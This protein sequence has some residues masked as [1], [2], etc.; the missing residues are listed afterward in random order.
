[1]KNKTGSI[2]DFIIGYIM[3]L[4]IFIPFCLF[5]IAIYYMIR[6]KIDKIRANRKKK[7][8]DRQFG[9]VTLYRGKAV[10]R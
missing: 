10:Y 4:F 8:D 2:I 7:K 9:R 3:F 1:M 5:G 6:T